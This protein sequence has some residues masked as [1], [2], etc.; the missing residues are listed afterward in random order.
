[1]RESAVAAQTPLNGF[2]FDDFGALGRT[3]LCQRLFDLANVFAF[4]FSMFWSLF[5]YF[6]GFGVGWEGWDDIVL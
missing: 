6:G 3:C 4:S 1:M 5:L 2:G